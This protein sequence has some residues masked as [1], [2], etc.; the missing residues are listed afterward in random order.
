MRI[1]C[2]VCGHEAD[3]E[4]HAAAIAAGW[5]TH[6]FTVNHDA[7]AWAD[8]MAGRTPTKMGTEPV[9]MGYMCPTCVAGIGGRESS[10]P[11]EGEG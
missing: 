3:L 1:S 6:T 2:T 4:S 11:P 9:S 8:R 7:V 5:Y 10:I